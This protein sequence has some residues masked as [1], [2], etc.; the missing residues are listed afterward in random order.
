MRKNRA[1]RTNPEF[2]SFLKKWRDAFR[3]P[4]PV[5]YGNRAVKEL[6]HAGYTIK[7]R[8]SPE[9]RISMLSFVCCDPDQR[10]R[11]REMLR[12]VLSEVED[13]KRRKLAWKGEFR[14]T[15]LFIA[16]IARQAHRRSV[17]AVDP[18]LKKLLETTAALI[19]QAR[20]LLNEF[21][22]PAYRS[23]L[24][25]WERLWPQHARKEIFDRRIELD[26][27]LQVQAAKMF[28]TFLHDDEGVSL[29]TI[30]RLVV[31]V[32]LV[33]GLASERKDKKDPEPLLW[34]ADSQRVITRRTVEDKLRRRGLR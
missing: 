18:R 2:E 11:P 12:K 16:R 1:M 34:I 8:S 20:P 30:A 19:E 5:W 26:T 4:S 29:R 24:G 14:E 23:P 10:W 27:H 32:Y 28:R 9:Q 33:A 17:D 15:E 6:K 31:L 22:D 3:A 25:V 21:R 7:P 13:Y